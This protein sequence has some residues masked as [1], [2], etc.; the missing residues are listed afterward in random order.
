MMMFAR[1][2]MA[3]R[4]SKSFIQYCAPILLLLCQVGLL[5]A[6]EIADPSI[7]TVERIFKSKEFETEKFGPAHWLKDSSGYTALEESI[8]EPDGNDIVLYN[9]QT[10]CREVMVPAARLIPTGESHEHRARLEKK[11]TGRLPGAQLNQLEIT[12]ARAK[13]QSLDAD[14][15]QVFTGWATNRLCAQEKPVRAESTEPSN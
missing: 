13:R 15:C 3:K 2:L 9:P 4:T 8:D 6:E 1:T 5:C 11:H 10:G 14:V 12:E 7:L